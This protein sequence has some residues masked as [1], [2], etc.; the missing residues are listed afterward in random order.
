[1]VAEY[2][3][4]RTDLNEVQLI[5]SPHNPLKEQRGLAEATHRLAM[6]ELAVADNPN[7]VVNDIE[8]ELPIPSY[9][10]STLDELSARHPDREFVLIIGSDN[11][12]VFKQW[13]DWERILD[14]YGCYTYAR[15]GAVIPED[16]ATHRSVRLYNAPLINVSATYIRE[17]ITHNRSTRYLVPD[18]V[19]E[20]IEQHEVFDFLLE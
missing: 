2:M 4:D 7:L 6:V 13:R 11:L 12:A 10:G 18:T 8:F 17:C 20:Y 1:M 9:T 5:V 16:L 14:V 3:A 19:R 15:T